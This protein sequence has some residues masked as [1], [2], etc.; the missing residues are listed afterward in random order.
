LGAAALITDSGIGSRQPTADQ[1]PSEAMTCPV[2]QSVSPL[3]S[4]A[5]NRAVSAGVLH[6]PPG[7]ER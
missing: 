2:I 1:P 6:R 4:Q 7:C 5:I 3:T